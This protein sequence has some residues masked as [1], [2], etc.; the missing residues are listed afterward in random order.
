MFRYRDGVVVKKV[1]IAFIFKVK[2]I[3]NTLFSFN[4]FF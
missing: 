4:G 3:F 2:A 1:K